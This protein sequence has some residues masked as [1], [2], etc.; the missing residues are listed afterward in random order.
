MNFTSRIIK[1]KSFELKDNN[2]KLV[3]KIYKNEFSH[4][5]VDLIDLQNFTSSK[6]LEYIIKTQDFEFQIP[7]KYELLNKTALKIFIDSNDLL[8]IAVLKEGFTPECI[9][10]ITLSAKSIKQNVVPFDAEDWKQK[11]LTTKSQYQNTIRS[12][13]EAYEKVEIKT[14]TKIN[15]VLDEYHSHFTKSLNELKKRNTIYL[16]LNKGKIIKS[17]IKQN[18]INRLRFK[19][20]SKLKTLH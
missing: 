2:L 4:L 17:I 3:F 20:T 18:E 16:L 1:L 7:Y 9:E 15:M 8:D 5:V 14:D 6:H 13:H 11:Y 19:I 12:I 10:E